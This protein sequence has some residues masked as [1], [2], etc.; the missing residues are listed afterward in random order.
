MW[1]LLSSLSLF[2]LGC[3]S[4][5]VGSGA[6]SRGAV[7]SGVAEVGAEVGIGRSND[8]RGCIRPR[9]MGSRRGIRGSGGRALVRGLLGGWG[10]SLGYDG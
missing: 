1:T 10:L 2:G 3:E 6:G 7:G 8:A 4:G 9:G 5:A